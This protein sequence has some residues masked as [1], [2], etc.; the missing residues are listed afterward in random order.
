MQWAIVGQ[1]SL[2]FLAKMVGMQKRTSLFFFF[3]VYSP[4]PQVL[5]GSQH[6]GSKTDLLNTSLPAKLPELLE[7]D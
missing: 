2:L 6:F 3:S 7:C 5:S 4:D 1:G